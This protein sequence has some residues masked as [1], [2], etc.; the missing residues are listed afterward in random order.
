MLVFVVAKW[1]AKPAD[2]FWWTFS[3]W[4]V[5]DC[6]LKTWPAS[7]T[8]CC[9][10]PCL[11]KFLW[12]CNLGDVG[13]RRKRFAD[14]FY[15]LWDYRKKHKTHAHTVSQTHL[16]AITSVMWFTFVGRCC[17]LTVPKRFLASNCTCITH[18]C[19]SVCVEM[20]KERGHLSGHVAKR[21]KANGRIAQQGPITV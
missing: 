11:Y 9:L 18:N 10:N 13:D 2:W 12:V 5:R 8:I 19:A 1:P 20:E 14:T 7:L 15:V 3:M 6:C 21:Q 4:K 17:T 16:H